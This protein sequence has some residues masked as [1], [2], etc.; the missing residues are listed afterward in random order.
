MDIIEQYERI[1]AILEQAR[2]PEEEVTPESMEEN[3]RW[4][5]HLAAPEV[6]ASEALRQR[7]WALTVVRRLSGSWRSER[8]TPQARHR[9][10][11]LDPEAL[12]GWERRTEVFTR[13]EKQILHLLLA[14]DIRQLPKDALLLEEAREAMRQLLERLPEPEREALL[15]QVRHGLSIREIAEVMSQTEAQAYGLLQQVRAALFGH[16]ELRFEA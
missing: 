12:W 13:R 8:S 9:S 4:L 3:L 6:P 15:L 7:V 2:R 16:S 5:I 11:R 14:A 1:V 10:V